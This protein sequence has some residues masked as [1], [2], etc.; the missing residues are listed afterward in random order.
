MQFTPNGWIIYFMRAFVPFL[1]PIYTACTRGIV[2]KNC[3]ETSP[4]TFDIST[5]H[6]LEKVNK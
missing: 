5:M 3:V 1:D 4:N 2:T 6:L